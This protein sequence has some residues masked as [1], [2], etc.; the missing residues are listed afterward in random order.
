M[1]PNAAHLRRRVGYI[2]TNPRFPRGMTP[3]TYLDYMARLFGL[4]ADVRKPREAKKALAGADFV[5]KPKVVKTGTD[6][7]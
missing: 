1:T 4:P 2:P 3:I 5:P 7:D 6:G